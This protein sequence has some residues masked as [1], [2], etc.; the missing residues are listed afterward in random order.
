MADQA[1]FS[2]GIDLGTTNSALACADLT[3]GDTPTPIDVLEIP[4]L[5]NPGEVEPLSLL[6]SFLYIV[7]DFDFPQSSLHLPWDP[8]GRPL[9]IVGEL[10]RKRGS[11]NPSRLVASAKSWLSDAGANRTM[12]ILPWGAPEG[13]PKLS[14]VAVSSEYLLHLRRSWD[15]GFA[16]SD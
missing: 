11:E 5:V 10:A 2:V 8:D 3:G 7:G 13:V 15:A 4:Q 1:H 9:H 14:P 16:S 12:P 6:P